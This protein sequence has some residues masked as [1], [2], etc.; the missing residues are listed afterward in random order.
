MSPDLETGL[1]RQFI[2]RFNTK[3]SYVLGEQRQ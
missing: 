1:I 3:N 2:E